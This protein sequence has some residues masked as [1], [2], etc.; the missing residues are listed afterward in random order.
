MEYLIIFI[1]IIIVFFLGFKLYFVKRQMKNIAKQMEE[2]KERFVSIDL[3]D[4]DLEAVVVQINELIDFTQMERADARNAE[5]KLR[6]AISMV[7]HDMRT[8][9]TSVIG[10][11]QLAKKN[12]REEERLQNIEIALDRAGYCNKLVNDFF[13]LSVIDSDTYTPVMEKVNLCELVC[14]EILANYVSFEEKG[15][16]PIFEQADDTIF[17]LADKKLLVR[18]L[19]NL[20]SNNI[21]YATGKVNYSISQKET[22]LL[23]ITSSST[24]KVDA[25]KI[26]DKFYQED[27]ARG[28][29]GSGL[30]LYICR[31]FMEDMNGRIWA[32]TSDEE[33]RI[34]VELKL[35]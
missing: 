29:E 8:P 18:V 24:R 3:I 25:E 6:T 28:S 7:S 17:V 35:Y 22:V 26:F 27:F 21:K 2:Q 16:M 15:I 20:I 10:Y 1:L 5:K 32:E 13:E 12:C 14:E 30:G 23:E 31:K 19:Q 34:K 11:L 33:F 9:L 4:K